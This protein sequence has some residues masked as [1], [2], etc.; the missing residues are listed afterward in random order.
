[1]EVG[2]NWPSNVYFTNVQFINNDAT[3]LQTPRTPPFGSAIAIYGHHSNFPTL[4]SL[5]NVSFT[6]N[7]GLDYVLSIWHATLR[8]SGCILFNGN[9]TAAGQPATN[10]FIHENTIL[11]DTSS[12]SHCPKKKEKT[13]VPWPTKTPRPPSS[14]RQEYT[15]LQQET[16]I[17]ISASHGLGSGVHFRQ[18]DGAGIGIQSLRRRTTGGAGCLWLC[19]AG[20][21]NLLP[22]CR[23]SHLLGCRRDSAVNDAAASP[24]G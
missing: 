14:Y 11:E 4:V 23:P 5:H 19:R 3:P 10:I 15:E 16:G 1:M 20:G 2:L 7:T 21:R 17:A 24:R 13:P 8:M 18:L 9:T 22:V 12:S 6:R